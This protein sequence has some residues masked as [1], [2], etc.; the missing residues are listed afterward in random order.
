MEYSVVIV[1]SGQGTRMKLG[2]NKVFY[3]LNNG[4][5]ILDRTIQCFKADNECKEII[6]VT[7]K[8]YFEQIN[9]QGIVLTT[10]GLQRQD[11]VMNGLALVTYPYVMIHDGARPNLTL[12]ILKRLKDKLLQCD[13]CLLMVPCKDTIK[14][15]EDGVCKETLNRALLYQAQTPQAFKTEKLRA[16]YQLIRD[17]V[18]T[19][20]AAVVETML[21]EKVHMVL[22]DESNL[23][24][25][26]MTDLKNLG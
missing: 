17:E 12:D 11:S 18:F 9:Q 10:G 7:N 22:G 3:K 4:E 8:E 21:A 20:D 23:K 6:V 26:T 24:V 16:A 14:I 15:V 25:T 2:Y 19:D 5:T 1:A 13:A